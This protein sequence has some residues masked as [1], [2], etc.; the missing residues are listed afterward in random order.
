MQAQGKVL[1]SLG[2]STPRDL[3]WVLRLDSGTPPAA[4]PHLFLGRGQQVGPTYLEP[5]QQAELGLLWGDGNQTD[6]P[7]WKITSSQAPSWE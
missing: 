2:S 3:G 7:Q 4:C 1:G 6:I 5:G